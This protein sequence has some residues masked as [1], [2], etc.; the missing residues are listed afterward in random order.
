MRLHSEVSRGAVAKGPMCAR[1]P[2]I[3]DFRVLDGPDQLHAVVQVVLFPHLLQVDAL[4][5]VA[6]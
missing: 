6:A 3:A 2:Y 5:P 1:R 4:R